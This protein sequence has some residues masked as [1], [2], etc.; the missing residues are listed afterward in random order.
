MSQNMLMPSILRCS[1][2]LISLRIYYYERIDNYYMN[3][4][5]ESILK[6][7]S[8]SN[9][10]QALLIDGEWGSGKTYFIKENLMKN[11]ESKADDGSRLTIKYGYISLFGIDSLS[12]L[13]TRIN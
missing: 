11:L 12:K 2:R 4:Y 3:P 5:I 8:N 9:I 1:N 10:H 6:Y 7:I 13:T